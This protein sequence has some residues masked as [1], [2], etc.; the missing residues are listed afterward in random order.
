MIP[1]RREKGDEEEEEMV[2]V[3]GH[4]VGVGE[5][6]AGGSSRVR[7]NLDNLRKYI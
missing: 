6:T 3:D 1:D 2:G 4:A 5:Y 7:I